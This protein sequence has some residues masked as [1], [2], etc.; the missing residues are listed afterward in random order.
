MR[1]KCKKAYVNPFSSTEQATMY[2]VLAAIDK[3]A[4]ATTSFL[5]PSKIC[6]I[7]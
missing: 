2:E 5:R 7:T 4:L 6:H 1:K 3:S